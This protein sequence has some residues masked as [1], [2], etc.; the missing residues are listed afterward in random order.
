[1]TTVFVIPIKLDLNLD[2]YFINLIILADE[3]DHIS[4]RKKKEREVQL[5]K[6]K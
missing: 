4:F 2:F 5:S 6:I 3:K 1:M